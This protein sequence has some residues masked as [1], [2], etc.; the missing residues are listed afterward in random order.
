MF[1]GL[2]VRLSN[3]LKIVFILANSADLDGMPSSKTFHLFLLLS[4]YLFTGLQPLK[5]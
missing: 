1:K 4:K 5:S 3:F 2:Q